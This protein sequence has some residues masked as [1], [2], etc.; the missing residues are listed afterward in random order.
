[1][2]NSP[3]LT[4]FIVIAM[5]QLLLGGGVL[6]SYLANP[7]QSALFLLALLVALVIHELAHAITA[8]RLGDPNP[9]I[10]GR[11]SLN[12]LK[13][14]DPIGTVMIVVAGFGWGKPVA[15]DPY[16][17][18]DPVR[19]GAMIA[20]AGPISNLL[21]AFASVGCLR[22]LPVS[23]P[24]II[25][26]LLTFFSINISLALFNLL[27]IY[28][29]DGHHIL[30]AFFPSPTR[31]AYDIFNRNF[32]YIVTLVLLFVP[33]NGQTVVSLVLSPATRWLTSMF[34]GVLNA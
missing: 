31:A 10:A 11:I 9:R 21:L 28:P 26:F 19:D 8:D 4:F 30:R 12:P 33:I 2:T 20:A 32:G 1:M 24:A 7:L 14:L 15:F 34:L 29:L 23:A 27:P 3:L 13:H 5:V 18:K 17:L 22:F 6:A 25:M 16:N